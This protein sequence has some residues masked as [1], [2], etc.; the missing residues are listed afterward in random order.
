MD[1]S[2]NSQNVGSNPG[3]RLKAR[4]S[5]QFA[6]LLQLDRC[7]GSPSPAAL[8][9]VFIL[10]LTALGSAVEAAMILGTVPI[11]FVGDLDAVHAARAAD[12]LSAGAWVAGTAGTSARLTG[13]TIHVFPR[14]R[15][16]ISEVGGLRVTATT[17]PPRTGTGVS[18]N[19]ERP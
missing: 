3:L 2:A 11:A 14:V 1:P 18:A 16:R 7:G 15:Y 6:R 8:F 12:V 17:T 9:G 4:I 10:L 19:F 5:A 13:L